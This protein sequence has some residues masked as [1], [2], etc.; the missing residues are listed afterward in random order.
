[1]AIPEADLLRIGVWC[2]EHV[3][4]HVRD[5]LRIECEATDRH[6]TILETRPPWDGVGD[7][8]RFP[9][10][11]LRYTGTTGQWRLYWRD[12]NLQFHEYAGRRPTKRVQTLLDFLD[13]HED[14]IFWG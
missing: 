3:P 11:R 10:A 12:R 2:R 6:V 1:M 8:T 13:S 4:A 9:I 7:W 14:P 5:Q